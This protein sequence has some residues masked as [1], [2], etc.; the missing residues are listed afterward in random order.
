MGC[1]VPENTYPLSHT[2][3]ATTVAH[4]SSHNQASNRLIELGG[5][6]A[7]FVVFTYER[8][9]AWHSGIYNETYISGHVEC[10]ETG[11]FRS[12]LLTC[13][14]LDP[15][16]F[17][18]LIEN[19]D[20]DLLYAIRVEGKMDIESVS[21]HDEVKNAIMEKLIMLRD[22]PTREECPLIYHLD[23]ATMI[24]TTAARPYGSTTTKAQNQDGWYA[25]L[26]PK[27]TFAMEV[28]QGKKYRLRRGKS[29][30]CPQETNYFSPLQ[31][32]YDSSRD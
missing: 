31:T 26:A 17:N 4:H 6:A 10:L 32:Q 11:V 14:K 20:R 16:A 19:L 30:S 24:L 27:D 18:V 15:S 21:N 8:G 28:E 29:N 3:T 2:T 7:T 13:F 22:E 1:C 9:E 12:D 5:G 25:T 23:V